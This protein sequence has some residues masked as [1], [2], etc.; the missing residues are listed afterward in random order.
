MPDAPDRPAP[1]HPPRPRW[2]TA[3]LIGAAVLLVVFV[4]LHLTGGGMRGHG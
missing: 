4:A 2:V 3:L 1:Q